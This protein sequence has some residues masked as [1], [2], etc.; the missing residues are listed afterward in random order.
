MAADEPTEDDAN[1]QLKQELGYHRRAEEANAKFAAIVEFSNDAIIGYKLDGTIVTWNKAAERIFAY[2]EDEMRGRSVA[3]LS[4]PDRADETPRMNQLIRRGESVQLFETQHA[5][6]DGKLID[7]SL[8]VS[9]IK[10]AA[11]RIVGASRIARDITQ[12]KRMEQALRDS[13]AKARA[14]LDT[15]VDGIITI[16][17]RGTVDSINRAAE[18]LFGYSADEVIGQNV[19]MLMPE[20]YAG[21]HDQ[22][23]RNYLTTHVPKIIGI[24]REVVALR[25]DGTTFPIEL[26]VSEVRL[27]ER[28][29]FTGIVRDISERHRLEQEVLDISDREKRRIG[30]DLHDSLGQ[31]LTGIGFKSKSLENKMTAKALPEAQTAKQIAEL[32]TQSITQARALARGL[33]P[34][35]PNRMGLM[36]ALAELAIAMES[37][38]HVQCTFNCPQPVLLNDPAMG[39]HLY[40]IAQEAANNAVKHG[41]ADC[42]EISLVR[43]DGTLTL[44]IQDNGRGFVPKPPTAGSGMGLHIMRYRAAML[45]GTVSIQPAPD[46]GTV[47]TCSIVGDLHGKGSPSSAG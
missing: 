15:A 11:G 10:D 14:I 4:P 5:R 9:P 22:Y 35:E 36:T 18:R 42:I 29:I 3:L 41:K 23:M 21:E 1:K 26:A 31:L 28:R 12:R 43:L 45:G 37:L 13:E 7:V 30:Q 2:S 39:T 47:V 27:G 46:G 44:K 16:D 20:P 17:E 6:K 25:K 38:F 34:V 24:G 32:V 33:Q 40:R 8:T 19:K